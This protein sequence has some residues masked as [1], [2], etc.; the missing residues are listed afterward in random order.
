MGFGVEQLSGLLGLLA[1]IP[2][3]IVY[4]IKP[5]PIKMPVPSLMFFMKRAK[6]TTKESF[7][8]VFQKDYLFYI[9]LLVLLLLAFSLAYPYISKEEDVV[10]KNLV[11]V[12]DVSASSQVLEGSKTRFDIAKE[13]I[14][15]LATD[16]NTIVLAKSSAV[17]ALKNANKNE[18]IAFL[19]R[20]KPAED[21]SRIGDAM[22]LAAET[23][24]GEKGRIV[25]VSDFINTRGISIKTAE[26]ILKGK[27]IVV[28]MIN[29][30]LSRHSNIGIIDI[31]ADEDTSTVY[32]RNFNNKEEK[33]NLEVDSAPE[34]LVVDANN[35]EPFIYKTKE[36]IS[37]V[38]IMN[39]DDFIV[40]NLAFISNPA[41]KKINIAYV[42]NFPSR[43][44]IAALNSSSR[45][46]VILAE[47]P[48]LPKEKI[49]FYIIGRIDSDKLLAGTMEELA[50]K[51][52][53]GSAA[54]I[55]AYEGIEKFDFNGLKNLKF[56]NTVKTDNVELNRVTKFTKDIDFGVVKKAYSLIDYKGDVIAESNSVP[57]IIYSEFGLGKIVYYGILESESSFQLSPDYP[58]FWT[59]L[60]KFLV[61][62]REMQELNLKTGMSFIDEDSNEIIMDNVGVFNISSEQLVVNMLY[63]K[64]S[65]INPGEEYGSKINAFKFSAVKEEVR[66]NML[67]Y[68][69]LIALI[70]AVFEIYYAKRRGIL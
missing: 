44:L 11:F 21:E 58:V 67:D 8:R 62:A 19:N 70:L 35:M 18:L 46:R 30:A 4:L 13:E 2:F 22:I 25:V 60:A 26:D 55:I 63:E 40:D 34:S 5:R 43:F 54:V 15:K 24:A 29:T 27:G 49:D 9:Q 57:L 37:R 59:G 53:D 16:V 17:I 1:V 41:G 65:N 66:D 36:G 20:L 68:L 64:E 28:D 51:V 10:S 39:K 50:K 3:I 48:V 69:L 32:I 12:L 47:P 6:A 23:L 14:K 42:T 38:E 33:V 31:V 45:I 52:S 61:S 7:L 56:N